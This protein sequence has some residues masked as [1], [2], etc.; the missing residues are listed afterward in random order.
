[1]NKTHRT[2][3]LRITLRDTLLQQGRQLFDS[4]SF[5]KV[6]MWLQKHAFFRFDLTDHREPARVV[7][8][9]QLPSTHTWGALAKNTARF[10][11][12]WMKNAALVLKYEEG[13][14]VEGAGYTNFEPVVTVEPRF[15]LGSSTAPL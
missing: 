7:I 6:N 15:V 5:I 14:L 10:L 2:K 8:Y 1:M 9:V 13:W 12:L 11:E 3:A 4:A